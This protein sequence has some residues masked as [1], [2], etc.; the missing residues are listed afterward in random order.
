MLIMALGLAFAAW[1]SLLKEESKMR[2]LFA[3]FAAFT[4]VAGLITYLVGVPTVA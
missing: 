1:A 2:L 4:L 3:F